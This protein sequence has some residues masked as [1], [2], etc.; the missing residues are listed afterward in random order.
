[1]SEALHALSREEQLCLEYY[2]R[3]LTMINAVINSVVVKEQDLRLLEHPTG[4]D[5][6]LKNNKNDEIKEL[7]QL[8]S[9]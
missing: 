8:L 9:R 1:M 3:S 4:I 5:T 2:P 6:M 7:Y